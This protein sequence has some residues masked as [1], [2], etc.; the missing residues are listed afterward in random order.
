M[1]QIVTNSPAMPETWVWSLGWEDPLEEGMATHSSMLAWRILWTEKPGRLQATGSQRAGHDSAQFLPSLLALSM[2][3]KKH[4][5]GSKQPSAAR[6]WLSHNYHLKDIKAGRNGRFQAWRRERY[7]VNLH[8]LV[9]PEGK[10]LANINGLYYKGKKPG[11]G[12][13]RPTLGQLNSSMKG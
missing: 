7:R 1:A 6:F 4:H 13:H 2:V 5:T 12:V 3:E 10:Q 11:R 9:M 8:Y